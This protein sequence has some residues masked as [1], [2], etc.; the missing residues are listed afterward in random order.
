MAALNNV[1]QI[2]KGT[3]FL[4][5]SSRNQTPN[6]ASDVQISY[7]DHPSAE[8][9]YSTLLIPKN[10]FNGSSEQKV[11]RGEKLIGSE[12]DNWCSLV[13]SSQRSGAFLDYYSYSDEAMFRRLADFY[14]HAC[15]QGLPLPFVPA[16]IHD[17]LFASRNR[18]VQ[19]SIGSG[20]IDRWLKNELLELLALAQ[21]HGVKTP[22]L[23][24]S[25]S[26]LVALNF[27]AL[28]AVDDMISLIRRKADGGQ[29]AADSQFN[30]GQKK[31][32]IWVL[33]TTECI[34]IAHAASGETSAYDFRIV[35]P[36]TQANP[37]IVAQKGC[38]TW[39]NVMGSKP[40]IYNAEYVESLKSHDL[41]TAVLRNFEIAKQTQKDGLPASPSSILEC[42]TLNYSEVPE[43]Y[44]YL[45]ESEVPPS[46]LYPG[47]D[48]CATEAR[49]FEEANY[50]RGVAWKP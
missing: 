10:L 28:G 25:R 2:F 38:F 30:L 48:G 23:D 8:D 33:S 5:N 50:I 15:D 6:A 1:Y 11:F 37:N 26:P 13:P 45:S 27:A 31:I 19:Q 39:H 24:W 32:A 35:T 7:I 42:H 22:L 16:N 9:L 29:D 17:E 44:W 49:R 18:S 14:I 4:L 43:L 3:S 21:H 40:L 34:K 41:E 46:A 20:H 47:F 36:P 12:E